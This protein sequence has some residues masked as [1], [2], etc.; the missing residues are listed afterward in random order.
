MSLQNFIPTLWSSQLLPQLRA[1]LVFG[2]LVQDVGSEFTGGVGDTL[3]INMIGDITVSSYTKDTSIGAPQTLSDAQTI[4]AISQAKYFNFAVDDVDAAQQMP[5]VMSE[6]M[7]WAAYKVALGIDQYLAG[8]YTEAP[9]AN[10][11][12]SSG[13]PTTVT[14]PTNANVGGGTTVYDELVV[15]S[16]FLTQQLVPKQGRW[17]VI[18][19]WCKTHLTQDIRFTS[20]NTA[21][22]TANIQQY[23]F[24]SQGSEGRPTAFS[25]GGAS[26]AYLGMIENMRVYESVNA[27]HIG[28]TAGASGSQDA[29]IAGHP[30]AWV[31]ADG[32]NKLEAYRPPDKFEDAIKG[33]HLYGAK[34]TR[35][36]ALAVAFLQ[37]P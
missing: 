18:P 23:G 15:L 9:A 20:F 27:P 26:D 19:P 1:D 33:L 25:P 31:Y 4:L 7:Q 21:Q 32:V 28:G 3:K 30:M 29:I 13:S 2:S 8:F 10:L 12:G 36:Y 11:I 37:K 34:V 5:K 6:A 16:Q 17:V 24:E 35:P 22:A 14:V